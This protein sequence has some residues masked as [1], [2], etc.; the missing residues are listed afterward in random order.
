MTTHITRRRTVGR[1]APLATV[2][3]VA[4]VFVPAGSPLAAPAG[5]CTPLDGRAL[6]IDWQPSGHL[7]FVYA[8]D[9]V[10]TCD[11]VIVVTSYSSGGPEVDH[12]FDPVVDEA[13]FNVSE[14][15]AAGPAGVTVDPE[16]DPCWAGLEVLRD[17]DT[18]L[19]SDVGGDGCEM[20]VT[21]DFHGAP[22]ETEIH[23]VQQSGSIQP[24]HIFDHVG[25]TTTTLTGLPNGTWYVKVYDGAVAGTTMSVD[26]GVPAAVGIVNGVPDG[27]SV[28]IEHPAVYAGADD[29]TVVTT[30]VPTGP[31]VVVSRG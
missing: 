12:T 17:G 20:E 11:E 4:A 21:T 9:D 19:W 30:T 27:S 2:A 18:Y 3:V 10:T 6:D 5:R 8:G 14:L 26:G 29:F 23:V 24:P 13:V 25:D 16:L 15:E 7:K 28:L 31:A 1:L 22:F